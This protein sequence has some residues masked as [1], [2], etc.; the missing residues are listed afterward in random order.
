MI[1]ET[2]KQ[3]QKVVTGNAGPKHTQNAQDFLG[4]D[5]E[6]I[7]AMGINF[8]KIYWLRI[9]FDDIALDSRLANKLKLDGN[10]LDS[11]YLV[12]KFLFN[13][14]IDDDFDDDFE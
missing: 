12:S 9:E 8:L 5:I 6:V 3:F 7:P 4:E 14:E 1:K 10:F 11:K 2:M 13:L